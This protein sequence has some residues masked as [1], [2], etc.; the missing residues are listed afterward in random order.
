[1]ARSIWPEGSSAWPEH[2]SHLYPRGTRTKGVAVNLEVLE[3]AYRAL[4]GVNHAV[5]YAGWSAMEPSPKAS[6]QLA[7]LLRQLVAIGVADPSVVRDGNGHHLDL[8]SS[9]LEAPLKK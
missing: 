9:R 1:M 3:S 6:A 4:I 8:F 2:E 7:R 5:P